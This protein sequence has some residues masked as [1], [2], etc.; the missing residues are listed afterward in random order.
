MIKLLTYTYTQYRY[1]LNLN[2]TI[3]AYKAQ[4]MVLTFRYCTLVFRHNGKGNR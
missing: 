1:L 2:N 3:L 4:R